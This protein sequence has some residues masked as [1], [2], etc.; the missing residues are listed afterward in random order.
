[1][2]SKE[3]RE[4]TL[5]AQKNGGLYKNPY[6]VGSVEHNNFERGWSQE[7]KKNPDVIARAD[8]LRERREL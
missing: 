5:Y 4:G 2:L 8:R 6:P 1:V 3:Y 7:L